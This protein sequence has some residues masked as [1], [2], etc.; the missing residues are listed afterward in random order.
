MSG[1][2]KGST[3]GILTGKT[4]SGMVTVAKPLNTTD[5]E[6]G[7]NGSGSLGGLIMRGVESWDWDF[8]ER[9]KFLHL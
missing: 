3:K 4:S 8:L 2:E 5:E 6:S 7:R 9:N 1:G